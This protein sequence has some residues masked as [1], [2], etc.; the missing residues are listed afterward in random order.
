M[1]LCRPQGNE[2]YRQDI[3]SHACPHFPLWPQNTTFEDRQSVV[4]V[5]EPQVMFPP[6]LTHSSL[7]RA[8]HV[9]RFQTLQRKFSEQCSVNKSARFLYESS[10]C[11]NHFAYTLSCPVDGTEM[12][13][14]YVD[15]A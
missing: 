1:R 15:I 2:S 12:Y 5:E 8:Y 10:R 3:Q 14:D 9:V 11:A 6:S 13:G 4:R 7:Y